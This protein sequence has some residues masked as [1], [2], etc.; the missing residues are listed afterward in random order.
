[1]GLLPQDFIQIDNVLSTYDKQNIIAQASNCPAVTGLN[2]TSGFVGG[3]VTLTGTGFTGVTSVRF[4]NNVAATF[5]V[6]SDTQITATVPNGA[7]SG[8]ITLSKAG[9][10]DA[11][12]ASFT[13]L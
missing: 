3:T 12:S 8:A 11:Q 7:V 5:T 13:V 1:P 9:C 2:P 4:A 6:N 10:P